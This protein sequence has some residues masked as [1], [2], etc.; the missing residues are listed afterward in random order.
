MSVESP[1]IRELR[2]R[3][4]A[5][6]P[7][8]ACLRLC[9]I[10]LLPCLPPAAL[11]AAVLAG[12][13]GVSPAGLFVL[14]LLVPVLMLPWLARLIYEMLALL[15]HQRVRLLDLD[16]SDPLTRLLTRRHFFERASREV[17]LAARHGTPL[18]LLLLDIDRL[19]A[20]NQRHG[21]AAGD[22]V[23]AEVAEL[24]HR[25][26][27][28]HDLCGRYGGEE[29]AVLLPGTGLEGVTVLVERLIDLLHQRR[30]PHAVSPVAPYVTASFGAAAFDP[31]RDHD[32]LS[33][34]RRADS[35]LYQAKLS[36][37]DRLCVVSND[38]PGSGRN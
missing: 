21:E 27:R 26:L 14:A 28:L 20:I 9:L 4:L 12:P 11:L 8:R 33:L 35:A 31:E 16:P 19:S 38:E 32:E 1:L 18:S 30:M 34:L 2:H 37:R 3:L 36:G 5:H 6:R 10:G 23:L 25:P 22:Q 24:V 7:W 17:A 29:F 13:I 15:D